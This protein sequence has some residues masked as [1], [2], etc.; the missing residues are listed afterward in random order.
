MLIVTATEGV[1]VDG[2]LDTNA[3]ESYGNFIVNGGGNYWVL[4]RNQIPG[5]Y[6]K[7]E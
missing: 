6:Y 1:C 2:F 7:S 5:N 3:V 4:V